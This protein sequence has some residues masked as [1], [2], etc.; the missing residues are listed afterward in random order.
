MNTTQNQYARFFLRLAIGGCLVFGATHGAW[1]QSIDIPP[2]ILEDE[3]FVDEEIE[4]VSP[5]PRTVALRKLDDLSWA[6]AT[7]KLDYAER[8][9]K[10]KAKK[11][12][13]DD[14]PDSPN[15]NS[16]GDKIQI[17]AIALA[18]VLIALGIYAALRQPLDRRV[19]RPNAQITPENIDQHLENAHIDPMLAQALA[20]RD[21][22]LAIRYQYLR[23]LQKL[24]LR[25]LVKLAAEKTNRQ[26]LRELE[27]SG[28]KSEFARL[29][30][31]YENIW[32]GR[33]PVDLPRY[34][35][36]SA[37]YKAFLKKIS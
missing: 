17:I 5:Q 25:Q 4:A 35:E 7:D 14:S 21:Y 18:L 33:A 12:A 24:G 15:L 32:Y 27:N 10:K 13:R 11:D 8:S 28:L 20:A 2:E 22:A 16:L 34:E 26:Y 9:E 31:V 3:Y 37:M 36:L 30:L 6:E 19:A 23:C 29:T 1:A